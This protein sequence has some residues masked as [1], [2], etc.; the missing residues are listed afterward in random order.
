MNKPVILSED[1]LAA[2]I[3]VEAPEQPA[4]AAGPAYAIIGAISVTHLLN[5]LMQSLIPAVYPILKD[6]YALDFSQI[7]LITLAFMFTSSLLQPLVGAYTDK[8]PL[9]FSLPLGM[10][11]TFA[12]LILLSLAHHYGTILIA[13][14]LVGTG[15]AVFHPESSRIA[16]MASG[17][18]MGFAQAVF[19]VGGNF[20]TAIGPVLAAL[21]VVPLG[22]G[23]IAW[24]SLVAALAIAILWQISRWYAPRVAQRKGGHAS[25]PADG[26]SSARTM[27]ALGVLMVLLFSK[28]FY[29]ASIGSYY[30]FYLMQKF[31]VTTQAAQLYLFVFLGASA[32]GVFF[33]GPLGDRFGR[34]YVIWFSIL[35]A[36]PFSLALPYA[37]LFWS[38]VLSGMIGFIISSSMPAII[39]YAQ[40][41]MPHRLGMISGL[42][43]GM[44]F[45]F[46]GIGAAVL[47]EVADWKGIAFVY[48]ICAFLPAIGLLAVFLPQI[49]R[50]RL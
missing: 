29:T 32:V 20:G 11:F 39:V 9:P 14:A 46:G 43:Y 13:A 24:F 1:T 31:G 30:T 12:G 25:L 38:A 45:G 40:E 19:Q 33:G 48:Q 3:V 8:R 15:S 6:N 18:R 22:Q 27:A 49:K 10:G 5:D 26:P 42:F 34:K 2:P 21:I 47:G 35:G 37:D 28:T 17:G 7:G 44:A 36:L 16:R 41:L 4:K 23:S 50:H